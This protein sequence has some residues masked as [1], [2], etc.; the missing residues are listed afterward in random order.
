M[1][2]LTNGWTKTDELSKTSL[3]D[4]AQSHVKQA[5]KK[6]C[7]WHIK[8]TKTIIDEQ[9]HSEIPSV[10]NNTTPTSSLLL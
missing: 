9:E 7:G 5:T 2:N 1:T 10:P 6:N 8:N 3:S 4:V